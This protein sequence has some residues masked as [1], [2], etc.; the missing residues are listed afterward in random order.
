[1][2]PERQ[3]RRRM[4]AR[5]VREHWALLG[6]ELRHHWLAW[7]GL[8]ALQGFGLLVLLLGALGGET[9]GV[10]R[11]EP[12]VGYLWL[13]VLPSA[14]V[15][16][17]RL[18]VS[19]YHGRTQ[20]F[21]EALPVSR[22]APLTVKLALGLL[23]LLVGVLAAV[24]V[25]LLSAWRYEPLPGR[26]IAMLLVC[27]VGFAVAWWT[28]FFA[29][30]LAGRMRVPLYLALVMLA[31][32]LS[33]STDFEFD[34][35]AHIELAAFDRLP[36]EREVWPTTALFETLG[37]SLFWV[38]VAY[39][40]ALIS[41]GSLVE[42]LG[43]RMSHKE[44]ALSAI[45][46]VVLLVAMVVLDD[47]RAKPPYEFVDTAVVRSDTLPLE[48]AY[49]RPTERALARATVAD[50]EALLSELSTALGDRVSPALRIRQH[51]GLDAS[52]YD[53]ADLASNDGLLVRANLRAPDWDAEGFAAEVVAH[54]LDEITE[55]RAD[56]EPRAWWRD[57]FAEWWP[58]RRALP[59]TADETVETPPSDPC[60]DP[61][62]LRA[63]W[64]EGAVG[65]DRDTVEDWFR[66][67]ERLGRPVARGLAYS[68]VH[69][70]ER[71]VGAEALLELAR[72]QWGGPFHA[73]LRD[74]L[75]AWRNP[76]WE[77]FEEAL[78]VTLEDWL[79]AWGDELT[80]LGREPSCR[81][82][83]ASIPDPATAITLDDAEGLLR[84]RLRF[85]RQSIGGGESEALLARVLHEQLTPF[86]R[87]LDRDVLERIERRWP[88]DQES[89]EI[90]LS[91]VY[92]P[93]S[94]AFFAQE[95]DSTTLG[96]PLRLAVVRRTLP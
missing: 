26:F 16:G 83:L 69:V 23:V 80:R 51:A 44:K 21:V 15:L 27:S 70:L 62:W 17:N 67:R 25:V 37:W 65:L 48:V 35:F 61:L 19:E 38:A 32:V 10:S 55:G 9:P 31:S 90:E 96:C 49:G 14:L 1:M 47:R 28:F 68:G 71:M 43:R 85:E 94:R 63:L 60:A 5:R 3:S 81:A 40:L 73:D 77:V 78:G 58:R 36:Y 4:G 92:G 82:A 91:G 11:I 89:L 6:K 93:G 41:E 8:L 45:L 76:P 29:L 18:V 22:T 74:S 53:W 13:F 2:D 7:L 34:R 42:S 87:P 75:W 30:G 84:V 56:H 52:T 24:A 66:T 86:D 20:L 95:V 59:S 54:W 72:R 79:A 57:G 46:A 64:A 33:W 39:T 12:L 88:A 50:L